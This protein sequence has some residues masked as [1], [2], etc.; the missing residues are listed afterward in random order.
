MYIG[1]FEPNA[2]FDSNNTPF[3]IQFKDIMSIMAF[4]STG[5]TD[6]CRL[7]LFGCA[8]VTGED[9]LPLHITLER[10]THKRHQWEI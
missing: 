7:S 5:Q 2:T 9:S 10:K 4:V 1:E 8:C 3:G 6:P